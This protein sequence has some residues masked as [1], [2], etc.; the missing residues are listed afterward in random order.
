MVPCY[1]DRPR[2]SPTY[3]FFDDVYILIIMDA[4]LSKS[5]ALMLA[6]NDLRIHLGQRSSILPRLA[7]YWLIKLLFAGYYDSVAHQRT[8][9]M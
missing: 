1:A 8:Y 4:Q 9:Y 5:T 7:N 2:D 6:V 3:P